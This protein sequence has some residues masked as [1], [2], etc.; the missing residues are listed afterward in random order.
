MAMILGDLELY[1]GPQQVGGPDDLKQVIVDFID[2]AE[3]RLEVAVQE[4]DSMDIGR[5]IIRARQRG[6]VVKLV[7]EGLYLVEPDAI[8]EPFEMTGTHEVN[9]Q[10]HNAALRATVDVKSD[11]NP[12]TFHQKFIVR[13]YESVLTGSTNFTDTGTSTNLNHLVVMHDKDVALAY[14]RE[15]REIQR[16]RFGKQSEHSDVPEYATVSNIPIKILFAP[17]HNPEMEIMKQMSK[18]SRRIDFAIFTFAQSSG[19]DDTMMALAR[20]GIDIRGAMDGKQA[21]QDWAATHPIHEAGV[22][23]HIVYGQGPLRKL[24]H[25]LMVIDEQI[26]VAGSFNYTGP[27]T[28]LND[29][30]IVIIGGSSDDNPESRAEQRILAKYALDE[31]DRI[32]DTYGVTYRG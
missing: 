5:A 14:R 6:V 12:S 3:R 9:R 13:D 30:N 28:K 23:L 24:H 25:K 27:A 15:F 32:I 31:I 2:G 29:E 4:L 22:D 7:L 10:I 8:L 21:N 11:F 26:I 17:D 18:A 1:M 16:G 19:I 20:G